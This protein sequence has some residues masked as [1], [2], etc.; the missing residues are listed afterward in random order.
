MVCSIPGTAAR[1]DR[2]KFGHTPPG[3]GLPTI[4]PASI[5]TP[6]TETDMRHFLLSLIAL[7]AIAIF[8]HAS[9]ARAATITLDGEPC[10]SSKICYN[11]PNDASAQIDLYAV[12]T[13]PYVYLYVNGVQYHGAFSGSYPYP[14][15]ISNLAMTDP[16]GNVAYLTATFTRYT[17]C[18]HSGRGQY[19]IVHWTLIGGSIVGDSIASVQTDAPGKFY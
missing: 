12:V 17:T 15:D 1:L 2:G 9:P 7:T 13:H 19:C 3:G 6:T 4:R 11:I 8:G 18:T 10:A 16:A 5:F 14:S